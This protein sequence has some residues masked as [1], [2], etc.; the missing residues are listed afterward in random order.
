MI[1]VAPAGRPLSMIQSLPYCGP[2]RHVIHVNRVVRGNGVDLLLSL[3]LRRPPP[4]A[5]ESHCDAFP[6]RP[7]LGQTVR[8]EEGCPDS[9]MPPRCELRRSANS[10]AG[11]QTR[12]VPCSDTRRPLESVNVRGIFAAPCSRSAAARRG[13]VRESEILAVADGEVDLDGIELRNRSKHRLRTDKVSDLRGGLS[14]DPDNE[15]SHLG[16]S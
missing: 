13:P 14:R 10:P 1:T 11:R 7:S 15:R 5:R 12:C 3:E 9:E 16:E 8:D 6:S 4:A 2:E